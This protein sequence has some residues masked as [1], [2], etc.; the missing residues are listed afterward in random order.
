MKKTAKAIVAFSAIASLAVATTACGDSSSDSTDTTEA[1]AA[2]FTIEGQWART[3]PMATDMGA[4]YMTITSSVDDALVSVAVDASVAKM[5]QI[6]E[7][8]MASGSTMMGSD[9]TMD[10]SGEMVMQ[11]VDK[12][13]LP[14]G[15]PVALKPGGYHIMLMELVAPLKTG[16]SI[17]VTLTF[18]S[19]ATQSVTVPVQDEAPSM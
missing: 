18:E 1:P 2:E 6:H 4:A 7:M 5:A 14:A 10:G 13:D 19:G 17:V 15:E 12:I 3:S 9:T 16:T 8:V 11:E